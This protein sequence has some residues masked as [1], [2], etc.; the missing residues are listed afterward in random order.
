MET[1]F[2]GGYTRNDNKGIHAVTLDRTAKQ[3]TT[4]KLVIEEG[5]PTYFVLNRDGSQLYTLT[6]NGEN[7]KPGIASYRKIGNDFELVSRVSVLETNGCYLSLDED[8]N[9]LYSANYHLGKLAVI[10]I[11]ADDSLKVTDIVT[12][13]GNGPHENQEKAHAHFIKTTN[14]GK[15]VL[16]CDLGTDEVHV[17]QLTTEYK[18]EEVSVYNTKPGTGPRHLVEH[19]TLPIIYVVGE[20]S[21]TVDVLRFEDGQLS[22]ITS[23][24]TVPTDWTEFNSSSAIRITDDGKFLYVSNRGHNS[25]TTLEISTD[26]ESLT[27]IQKIFTAGDFP[28]DFNFNSTEDYIIVGHQKEAKITLFHRDQKTGLLEE[29]QRDYD[30]PE[31]VCV[32]HQ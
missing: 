9:V 4:S 10:K 11:N 27:E 30:V 31:I 7:E 26:G 1:I 8:K 12:H 32:M 13:Q 22:P 2:L 20:L 6:E 25:I 3:L 16:S 17:Y 15:Y 5:N 18:L 28:R 21:Y 29:I 23:V 19:P 14:D 24:K